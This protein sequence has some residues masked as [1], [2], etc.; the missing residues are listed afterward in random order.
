MIKFHRIGTDLSVCEISHP[1]MCEFGIT[2]GLSLA[3]ASFLTAD[4]GV[5]AATAG[6]LGTVGAGALE[7][8]AIGAITDPKNPLKGAEG[9]AIT[10]GIASGISPFVG[11]ALGLGSTATAGIS[12]AIGGAAGAAATGANI[13]TGA[14]T[15]GIGNAVG[16]VVNGAINGP[17]AS[18]PN[19]APATGGPGGSAGSS[20]AP[21]SVGAAA[22]PSPAEGLGD[23]ASLDSSAQLGYSADGTSAAPGSGVSGA[24]GPGA[25]AP[26]P[27]IGTST[28]TIGTTATSPAAA[29]TGIGNAPA[30]TVTA[31]SSI[32]TGITGAG[33]SGA[34]PTLPAVATATPAASAAPASTGT[35]IGGFLKDNAWLLPAAGLAYE[36]T[37][38]QAPL[39][40]ESNLQASATNLSAQANQLQNYFTSGTLPPG[41]QSGITQASDAAKAAIRSQYA[42]M[43][44][45]GS[46]AEAQDLA[47][48]D[49]RAVS[50]GSQIALSLLQQGVSEQGMANQLYMELMNTSLNQDQQL[51]SSIAAF[52]SALVPHTT[53]NLAA[54]A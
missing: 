2:E 16:S 15:G 32:D 18:T 36:A 50:Q 9:G 34:T 47:A 29:A 13:G 52:S 7:G 37:A 5:G 53:V 38:G 6:V 24:P 30:G 35:G 40:G 26:S 28:P 31:P 41:I 33:L 51:G 42:S 14:L 21:A 25:G 22:A 17:S 27:S 10:G 39:P 20:A 46:S 3:I 54:A 44:N 48:V 43:G 12:G 49:S 23:V 1:L 45:T 11:D 19:A 4:V 8:G